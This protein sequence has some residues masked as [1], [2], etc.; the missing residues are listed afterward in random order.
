MQVAKTDHYA[1]RS[2]TE[3]ERKILPTSPI[4]NFCEM[5]CVVPVVSNTTTWQKSN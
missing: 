4:F 1:G 5:L 3:K 2:D